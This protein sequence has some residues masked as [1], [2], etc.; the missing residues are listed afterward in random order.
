MNDR[1][2]I[3]ALASGALPSGIAVVRISGPQCSYIME[4]FLAKAVPARQLVVRRIIDPV[5]RDIIDKAMVAN[6]PGPASFTGEDCL[7]FHVHGSRAII[8]KLLK[9]LQEIPMVRIG[10]PGEFTRRAFENARLQLT[11]IEGLSDLINAETESQRVLA[12]ARM[13]GGFSER[14]N[15]WRRQL[16]VCLAN[17]EAYLD[18][19]DEEDVGTPDID[20]L[21]IAINSIAAE[22]RAALA[23]FAQGRIIREGFRVGI[24]G[25]PNVGKS[26]LLNHLV[27]SEVA[28][29]TD[30]AGTTRDIK[31]V[32]VDL[33]G[34]LVVFFDSAGIRDATSKAEIEGVRRAREML[35]HS[36]LIIWLRSALDLKDQWRP[37]AEANVLEVVNK[38]DLAAYDGPGLAVSAKT[39]MGVQQLLEEI[40]QLA[41]NNNELGSSI[42]LSRSRDRQAIS[43]GLMALEAALTIL[44]TKQAPDMLELIAQDLRSAVFAL[45]RLLGIIDAENVLDELFSGFCIGK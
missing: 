34:Q 36:N 20:G 38:C 18:F 4:Q 31:E 32:A 2:T 21:V 15:G 1:K 3:I 40:K 43:D 10:E 8:N 30:E 45:Q 33:G 9:R 29:V 39:G 19:S 41:I 37:G 27:G 35:E 16:V 5:S 22:F 25:A 17:I 23:G 7:E 42:L 14:I 13:D 26:S 28:I 6:F 12:I 11:E 24:G 44:E